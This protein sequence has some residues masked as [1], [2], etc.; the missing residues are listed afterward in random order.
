MYYGPQDFLRKVFHEEYKDSLC[1]LVTIGDSWTW[2]D[3]I[4]GIADGNLIDHPERTNC[5]Y[6]KHLSKFYN[7]DWINAGLPGCN[8]EFIVDTFKEIVKLINNQQLNY[9]EVKFV[10]CLTENSR[11][12]Q[13]HSIQHKFK[14]N[15]DNLKLFLTTVEA[16]LFTKIKKLK[17]TISI[18][19]TVCV[20][21][22]FTDTFDE[23]KNILNDLLI[24]K[25]WSQLLAE[26]QGL[27]YSFPCHVV[28]VKHLPDSTRLTTEDKNWLFNDVFPQSEKRLSLLEKN[29]LHFKRASKHPNEFGHQLWADYIINNLTI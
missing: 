4:C 19:N 9:N 15:G 26:H 27:E 7:C 20:S 17:E 14:N 18:K 2:G 3:S 11:V 16:N 21:R 25:T 28:E 13:S 5:I 10:L 23:N 6:G 12:F 8:N 1:L 24:N 29:P 22:N